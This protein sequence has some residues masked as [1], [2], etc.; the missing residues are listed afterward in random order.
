M[1]KMTPANF[2]KEYEAYKA[3]IGEPAH[4][5]SPDTMKFFGDTMANYK[6]TADTINGVEYWV[7]HRKRGVKKSYQPAGPCAWFRKS[8]YYCSRMPPAGLDGGV[9]G[10]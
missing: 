8:D 6:V 1:S 3:S 7:L 10:V 4:Y 2:K 5:F 9:P